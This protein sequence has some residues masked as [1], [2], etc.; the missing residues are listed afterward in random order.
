[1]SKRFNRILLGAVLV[2]PL[3]LWS[4]ERQ[5]RTPDRQNSQASNAR[6]TNSKTY[7]DSRHRDWHQWNDGENQ[8]YQK[9]SEEHHRKG[10]FSSERE[11]DQERYWAWR[12][13][14]S[15]SR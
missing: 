2:L 13:K 8:S 3:S 15:D 1:M 11:R 14:H 6:Q 7:Y 9:Y 12:H 10:D 5:Q 4:Q